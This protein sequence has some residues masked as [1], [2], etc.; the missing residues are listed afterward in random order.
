[1][2]YSVAVWQELIAKSHLPAIALPSS[3]DCSLKDWWLGSSAMLLN[4]IRAR[5]HTLILL[6][7]WM[8][9]KE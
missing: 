2:P 9:W 3:A 6:E 8:I 5:W 1:L 4:T 7:W